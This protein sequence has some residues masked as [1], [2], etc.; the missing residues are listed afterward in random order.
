MKL[1]ELFVSRTKNTQ[2][3]ALMCPITTDDLLTGFW[4]LLSV[5]HPGMPGHLV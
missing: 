4:R 1:I 5:V 2:Q 3:M